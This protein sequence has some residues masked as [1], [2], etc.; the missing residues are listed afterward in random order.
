MMAGGAIG[1]GVDR[2]IYGRVVD[3][4]DL[5]VGQWHWPA[6]NVADMAITTGAGI[7]IVASLI[8][9]RTKKRGADE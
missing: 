5:Y 7:I 8:E 6:F 9:A 4:V 2:V 1:N 3:F